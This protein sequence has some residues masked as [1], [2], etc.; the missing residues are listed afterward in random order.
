MSTQYMRGNSRG[1]RTI[2][3]LSRPIRFKIL[4]LLLSNVLL[5]ARAL[6]AG[7]AIFAVVRDAFCN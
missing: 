5:S 3:I 4:N 7:H 2:T 1:A 6:I